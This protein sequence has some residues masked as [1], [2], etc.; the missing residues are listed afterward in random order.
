MCKTM[1]FPHNKVWNNAKTFD[2]LYARIKLRGILKASPDHETYLPTKIHF[3]S[4]LGHNFTK[5]LKDNATDT[6]FCNY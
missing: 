6:K 4:S 1:N 2:S 5:S 3:N